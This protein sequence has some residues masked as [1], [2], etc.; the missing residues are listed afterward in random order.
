MRAEMPTFPDERPRSDAALPPAKRTGKTAIVV[1]VIVGAALALLATAAVVW[2]LRER[3]QRDAESREA[4]ARA[5]ASVATTPAARALPPEET[6]PAGCAPQGAA[7]KLWGSIHRQVP[8]ALGA[9]SGSISLAFA[10][11]ASAAVGL[12]VDPK[13]IAVEVKQE[14]AG[15]ELLSAVPLAAGK[16]AFVRDDFPMTSTTAVVAPAPFVLGQIEQHVASADLE[17]PRPSLEWR[18][19]GVITAPSVASAGAASYAVTFRAGGQSGKIL[20]GRLDDAGKAVGQ[21]HTVA[22]DHALVGTPAVAASA[23]G[24]LIGF[25]SRPDE[26]SPWSLALARVRPNEPPAAAGPFAVPAGGP[27][28][29][30][31]SPSLAAFE[32]GRWLVQWTEGESGAYR[33]RVQQYASDLKPLGDAVVVSP[34]GLNAGQGTSLATSDGALV[35]F[36]VAAEQSDELWGLSL[37][38]QAARP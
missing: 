17:R 18:N 32:D 7:K 21:L 35:V 4:A 2:V 6:T 16:F 34:E 33:V 26:Q 8:P 37:R 36:I 23:A 27:G 1:G 30:A 5:P 19:V 29:N 12:A 3:A 28:K 20:F 25:A 31:I 22:R 24:A 11:D 13:T 38:C 14:Q 15:R 10:A 9:G